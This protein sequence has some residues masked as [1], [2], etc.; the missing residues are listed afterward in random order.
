[1]HPRSD[2]DR[3]V[4][5]AAASTRWLS[6]RRCLLALSLQLMTS[7]MA[8]KGRD[9]REN[10][11]FPLASIIWP[12]PRLPGA[13]NSSENT[14]SFVTLNVSSIVPRAPSWESKAKIKIAWTVE[15]LQG[16]PIQESSWSALKFVAGEKQNFVELIHWDLEFNYSC[17]IVRL[18]TV[19]TGT[20]KKMGWMK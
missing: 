4:S 15:L 7:A 9:H 3:W 1:M 6:L 8:N 11:A 19:N 14:G 12:H 13:G 17:S 18:V 20:S 2:V 16:G 5:R 10:S